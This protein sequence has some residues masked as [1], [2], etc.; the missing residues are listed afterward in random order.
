MVTVTGADV[1][2]LL[3]EALT[4][5]GDRLEAPTNLQVIAPERRRP[6]GGRGLVTVTVPTARGA[7]A[8]A[9][10]LVH[11]DLERDVFG[12]RG[13]DRWTTFGGE[14]DGW[15]WSFKGDGVA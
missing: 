14:R 15:H 10:L 7:H 13:E 6:A 2:A 5:F 1:Y 11:G 4:R 12:K 3:H 9:R 8:W